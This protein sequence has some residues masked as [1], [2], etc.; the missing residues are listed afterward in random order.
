MTNYALER[1][2]E[3]LGIGFV[4][5]KVGDRY[6]LEELKRNGWLF[7]GETSGHILALDRQTT[8]D[9]IVSALQV[10]SAMRRSGKTLAELTSD[11]MLLPAGAREQ[12][13]PCGL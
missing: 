11:L 3:E 7:G 9:G 10:L 8:G 6:V 4:R 2:F 13:H 1:R 5:A 12:A